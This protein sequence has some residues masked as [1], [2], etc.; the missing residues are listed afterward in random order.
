MDTNLSNDIMPRMKSIATIN[1]QFPT[2][3]DSLTY[4][5]GA[6]LL[7]FDIAVF[8]PSFPYLR[9][10]SF[11]NGGHCI[12]ID[13]SKTASDSLQHWRKEIQTA[14]KN[15]KTIFILLSEL[16]TESFATGSSSPRKDYTTYHTT[17]VNNYSAIP[18][19]IDIRNAKGRKIVAND[20]LFKP[21][22]NL[23]K[24]IVEYRVVIQNEKFAAAFIASD[25]SNLGGVVSFKD[26]PGHLV[27]LP[28]FDFEELTKESDNEIVWTPDAIKKSHAVVA[29]LVEIDRALRTEGADCTAPEWVHESKL[30]KATDAIDKEVEQLD[31]RIAKLKTQKEQKLKA[32]TE[33]ERHLALL[34]GTGKALEAAIERA[35]ILLGYGVENFRAGDLE[36]DHIIRS[37]EGF[38]MIGEAEGKDSSAVGI[39]KFR[40][41]ESNINEDFDRDEIHE[42]AK[43][44]LFGNG[45]RLT[46]PADRASEFTEKCLTSAK[47]L[48]TALVKTSDL[49]PVVLNILNNPEDEKFKSQCRHAIESTQGG[50]VEFPDPKK[51]S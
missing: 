46:K 20:Q 33:F 27:L 3:D 43:G 40:Q 16:Q 6:S 13:S 22:L 50:I 9:R 32:K 23:I 39:L 34:Y 17:S 37:P 31:A 24:D 36:I 18:T 14:I 41:L 11:S 19:A 2:V 4:H 30:P 44:V 49:Y 5:S 38:R 15:G 26:T 42:P 28:Y 10:E 7:D 47:R 8:D 48:G 1:T 45:F 12:S 29:Q 35:L 21:I 25:G 51:V